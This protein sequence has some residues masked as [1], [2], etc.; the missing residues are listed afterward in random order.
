MKAKQ[1]QQKTT[2][3]HEKPLGGILIWNVIERLFAFLGGDIGEKYAQE[4]RQ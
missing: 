2:E 4:P 1:R 3:N